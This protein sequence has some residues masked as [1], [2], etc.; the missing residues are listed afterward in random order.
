MKRQTAGVR[1]R[2]EGWELRCPHC[3]PGMVYWPLTEEFWDRKR[4]TRCRACWRTHEKARLTEAQREARRQYAREW[5]QRNP[6]YNRHRMAVQR[7]LFPTETAARR[8]AY[9]YNN[10]EKVLAQ[11]REYKARK[12]L[13]K[14][15]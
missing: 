11:Q 15:A 4:M 9:Y 8:S 10:R 14:A 13:E 6:E 3:P 7:R 2:E 1:W 12:A 5:N